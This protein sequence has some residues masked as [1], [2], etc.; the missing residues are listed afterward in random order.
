MTPMSKRS[1][2]SPPPPADTPAGRLRTIWSTDFD[3]ALVALAELRAD[4][5]ARER[6]LVAGHRRNGATW[7]AIGARLGITRQA[8]QQRH[9]FRWHQGSQPARPARAESERR[10]SDG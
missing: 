7:Q 2:P 6:T 1:K 5:D 10:A 4:L 8:A 3:A 9:S